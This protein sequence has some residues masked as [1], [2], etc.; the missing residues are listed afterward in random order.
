MMDTSSY[1]YVTATSSTTSSSSST[2]ETKKSTDFDSDDF[3]NLL[4]AQIKNQDPLEPMDNQQFMSQLTQLNSLNV[5]KSIDTNT[6][7]LIWDNQLGNAASFIGKEVEYSVNDG[8]STSTGVVTAVTFEDGA[9]MLT[10]DGEQV[11]LSDV[12]AINQA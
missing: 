3:M 12:I 9:V 11:A 8:A 4:L 10:I 5:L 2:S 7:E 1:S 6:K